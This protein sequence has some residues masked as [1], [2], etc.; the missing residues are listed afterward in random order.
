MSWLPVPVRKLLP[1]WRADAP[2]A[3]L[4][5]G[6]RADT[7][8]LVVCVGDSITQ[9]QISA[10]YVDRLDRRLRPAGYQLVNAGVN[11]DLA[12]NVL[13]R[14]DEVVACQPDV[15]TLLVGTNDINAR[16]DATWEQRYRKDQGLPVAPT[17]DFYVANVNAIVTHLQAE[18]TARIV[19]VEIPLLGEDLPGLMNG[20]V[21][22]YN[23]ALREIAAQRDLECLPL[24]DRLLGLLPA[25]HNPPPYAGDISKIMLAG[26]GSM[27]LRRS[28]DDIARRNGLVA[29]TD[30]IH[31]SDRA[32]DIV[33]ELIGGLMEAA[34]RPG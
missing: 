21:R 17:L 14:L 4:L 24:Y 27:L 12:F 34:P 6:R 9:G 2:E 16:F 25:G 22:E 26:L 10:N 20:L 3:F 18:T 30:H 31:L 8:T 13:A 15:V 11:G 33:A 28:W 19:L 23:A 7:K 1:G 5:D 29:L 32:A